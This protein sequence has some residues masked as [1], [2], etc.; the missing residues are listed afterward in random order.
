MGVRQDTFL[1][2]VEAFDPVDGVDVS[3]YAS[4]HP[5][6]TASSDTPASQPYTP[7][8]TLDGFGSSIW[9]SGER[10]LGGMVDAKEGVATIPIP[11]SNL[12]AA[13]TPALQQWLRYAW[14]GKTAAIYKIASGGNYTDKTLYIK[15]TIVGVTA[16]VSSLALTIASFNAVLAT[17]KL[18]S[19]LY[20]GRPRAVT[21]RGEPFNDY[22]TCG[23]KGDFTGSFSLEFLIR[24]DALPATYGY[25]VDKSQAG[26]GA[27]YLTVDSAGVV[28]GGVV[29]GANSW[30]HDS[31][32]TLSVGVWTMVSF[33]YDT[34]ANTAR[35]YFNGK[36]DT[37]GSSKTYDP[38]NTTGA[39]T[40]A[41]SLVDTGNSLACSIAESRGWSKALSEDEINDYLYLGSLSS[42]TSSLA[43]WH[44]LAEGT[45]ATWNDETTNNVDGTM[46]GAAM[47]YYAYNAT[48]TG[49]SHGKMDVTT[50]TAATTG[51]GWTVGT[52]G[53]SNY[54]LM[55]WGSEKLESSFSGT[56]RPSA[57]PST[58][59]CIRSESTVTADFAAGNFSVAV[60]VR[61]VTAGG[62][63]DGRARCKVW[64]GKSADG[65][66]AVEVTAG[67]STG[68]TVTNL[69]TSTT[70]TSTISAAVS[71]FSCFEEYIFV[72]VAWEIT[73]A[74][75]GA[76]ADVLIRANEST[77]TTTMA[78]PAWVGT[79]EGD[80]TIAGRGKPWGT[81]YIRR[82]E[83]LLIDYQK[84]IYA[85]ST[86]G[87]W[88]E[89]GTQPNGYIEVSDG[90]VDLTQDTKQD[91]LWS[92]TAPASGHFATD[93]AR[94]L[95]RLSA[96]PAL[97]LRAMLFGAKRGADFTFGPGGQCKA[98]V[99]DSAGFDA[100]L[101][102]DVIVNNGDL[103]YGIG[104]YW[105]SDGAGVTC[106]EA[107]QQIALS[108]R[109]WLGFGFDGIFRG[110][111]LG[112]I[113][114]PAVIDW[115]IGTDD[116]QAGSLQV[117][118]VFPAIKEIRVHYKP[119]LP[120]LQLSEIA[121][122]VASDERADLQRQFRKYTA[123]RAFDYYGRDFAD[124]GEDARQID[125][126]TLTVAQG[127]EVPMPTLA[128]DIFR[129]HSRM[130][131]VFT[132]TVKNPDIRPDIG[133]AATLT[134]P[135]FGADAGVDCLCVGVTR[136]IPDE[137]CSVDLMDATDLL[138]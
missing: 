134:A 136:N 115:T 28:E 22:V 138:S 72:Q 101:Y 88:D 31:T 95:F 50:T 110:R 1:L 100:A 119:Y 90:G 57:A 2:E 12:D 44:R 65:S 25:I 122:S 7:G 27:Y 104:G 71:A 37:L 24:L 49:A 126:E 9:S 42:T 112:V 10:L 102:D 128:T 40:F 56:A 15:G 13:A 33:V 34:T 78:T 55:I 53:A 84:Q 14:S 83:P 133:D 35:F 107:L 59:D 121:T 11:R 70:Q 43:W 127:G 68:S 51:T 66:D 60:A 26:T 36:A 92:M 130:V 117:R 4:S 85:V 82:L 73:G 18:N 61:A 32:A 41:T 105:T 17:K 87:I 96:A 75:G 69:T 113:D 132:L 99:L 38:V 97:G 77:V 19:S 106:A 129:T 62:A 79:Y 111:G 103:A 89:N 64:K 124:Y 91:D 29:N 63:Q 116:F 47:T 98:I 6:T 135:E 39:L 16:S 30:T 114:M 21:F 94:G 93:L 80:S 81:G 108:W 131:P 120:P 125:F 74:G 48:A 123:K 109:C 8:L 20:W 67:A 86:N 3:I 5:F 54:S 52:T 137:G 23:D 118:A 58:T 76:T 46:T 45:G